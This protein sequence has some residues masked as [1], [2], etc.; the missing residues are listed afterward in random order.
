MNK[1]TTFDIIALSIAY[2][3]MIVGVA[4]IW[5]QVY[6]DCSVLSNQTFCIWVKYGSPELTDKIYN[7][8]KPFWG[9]LK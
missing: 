1:E 4:I 2:F 3:G 6:G 8:T 9:I 5:I 7:L